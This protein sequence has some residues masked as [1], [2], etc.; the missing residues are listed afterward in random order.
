[1]TAQRVERQVGAAAGHLPHGRGHLSR[2]GEGATVQTDR[3]PMDEFRSE[4]Y[5]QLAS[6]GPS[7]AWRA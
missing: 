2:S 3:G 1:M 7:P 5:E 6:H 4:Y